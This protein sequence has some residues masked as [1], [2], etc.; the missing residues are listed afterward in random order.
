[1][2]AEGGEQ[3]MK[4]KLESWELWLTNLAADFAST[5]AG[6]ENAQ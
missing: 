4:L 6:F 2:V 3:G 5:C 1:M